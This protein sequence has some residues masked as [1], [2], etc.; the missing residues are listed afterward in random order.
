[1]V[2]VGFLFTAIALPGLF[3]HHRQAHD[4]AGAADGV[5]PHVD[6][7]LFTPFIW[8]ADYASLPSGH[9]TTAFAVL[10]AFGSLWPRARTMFLLYAVAIAASR[11]FVL[12]HYPSDV[13]AG[14]V[15]G[16][17]GALLVRYYFALRRLAFSVGPDGTLRALPGP[18]LQAHESGCPRAVGPI[19]SAASLSP[20]GTPK[21]HEHAN[22]PAVSVVVPVRNE[23]GNI[24]PLVAEIAAA[25]DGQWAFEVVYVDDGSQRRHRGRAC[26]PDGRSI[27]GCAGCGTRQSC[28]Q[29]AAVRT[30]VMA[31]RAPLVVTLDGDGQNDPEIH[32]RRCCA[33]SKP[34]PRA[35][36]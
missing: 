13:I 34:A 12:G 6:P 29:S 22:E 24:A 36:R 25:L 19:R 2:R 33:R 32:S 27:P 20:D 35:S 15:V 17:V 14:A 7:F 5:L 30:G 8:R 11:I 28:G 3:D 21:P 26:T 1:M 23:A 9:A 31:A 18:S 16:T 10:V 4:R